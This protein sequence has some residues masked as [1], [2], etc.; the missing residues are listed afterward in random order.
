MKLDKNGN[1]NFDERREAWWYMLCT[2]AVAH[3]VKHRWVVGHLRSDDSP[4]PFSEEDDYTNALVGAAYGDNIDLIKALLNSGKA[5]VDRGTAFFGSPLQAAASSGNHMMA[6]MLLLERV[7]PNDFCILYQWAPLALAAREGHKAVVE[8]LLNRG[9]VKTDC[10]DVRGRTPLALAAQQG[11]AAV[12]EMLLDYA[13]VENTGVA[14][15][16]RADVESRG[17]A[18]S[19]AAR[20]GKK[21]VVELLLA[22]K[23][24]RAGFNSGHSA[25]TPLM[26]AARRGHAE[27]ARVFLDR[28]DV[29]VNFKD[30]C[31]RTAFS[32]AA[33]HSHV[34]VVKMFM[35]RGDVDIN[36]KDHM[37]RTPLAQAAS[38][39]HLEVVQL[40]VAREEV[41][42]QA[43]DNN[44]ETPLQL[45][46]AN[47][48]KPQEI[49]TLRRLRAIIRVLKNRIAK[50]NSLV[51]S[52]DGLAH[53]SV[54]VSET[55]SF[56]NER[57]RVRAL[58]HGGN[59]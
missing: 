13:D 58:P 42:I 55:I 29:R 2:A 16:D 5:R 15:P 3:H 26:W 44:G 54:S 19:W 57:A 43:Q 38:A 50:G 51:K 48:A 59:P 33:S 22:Q 49:A 21:A 12:V 4:S 30:S 23:G 39:G 17:E 28:N 8:L 52:C 34:A 27:V 25:W 1:T 36:C 7:N 11:H 40:L 31:R 24:V 56:L 18:L 32:L 10:R 6:R 47:E 9:N 45:A 41:D 37:G 35:A 14:L 46:A 53:P 20:A